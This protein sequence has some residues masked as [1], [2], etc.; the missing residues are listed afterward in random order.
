VSNNVYPAS[1][2]WQTDLTGGNPPIMK[3]VPTDPKNTGV[4][5]YT[6]TPANSNS[7]YV[8]HACLENGGDTG[9]NTAAD[10]ACTGTSRAFSLANNN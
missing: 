3:A 7:T 6:Y 9:S 2:S 5:V 4:Y 8:L 10:A 1:G